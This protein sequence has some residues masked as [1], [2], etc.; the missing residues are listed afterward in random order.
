MAEVYNSKI[1]CSALKCECSIRIP[2]R[3]FSSNHNLPI[4]KRQSLRSSNIIPG[5]FFISLFAKSR[6]DFAG[7]CSEAYS[8]LGCEFGLGTLEGFQ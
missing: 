1:F 6:S 4:E 7:Q 5:E 3:T 2:I 8:Q